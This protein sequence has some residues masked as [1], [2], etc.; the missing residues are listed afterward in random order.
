MTNTIKYNITSTYKLVQYTKRLNKITKKTDKQNAQ[1]TNPWM[2]NS[3]NLKKNSPTKGTWLGSP[4]TPVTPPKLSL[5][6]VTHTGVYLCGRGPFQTNIIW[7]G[8]LG[9][10]NTCKIRNL[11]EGREKGGEGV[12]HC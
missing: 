4:P 5:T 2:I 11:G 12:D 8:K 3:K 7:N 10:Q 9:L 6:Q 1:D